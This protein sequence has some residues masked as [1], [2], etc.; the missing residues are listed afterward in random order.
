MTQTDTTAPSVPEYL[1]EL[2]PREVDEVFDVLRHARRRYLVD[3]LEGQT[4]VPL[5]DLVDAVVERERSARGLGHGPD[6]H[7]QV[8]LTMFHNH[9]PKLE[10][11]GIVECDYGTETV[12]VADGEK[13]RL[14]NQLRTVVADA[15]E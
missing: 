10:E 5:G 1:H 4:V 9:L 14:V 2:D 7:D 8:R 11:A 3:A 15:A 6:R 13:L 12:T